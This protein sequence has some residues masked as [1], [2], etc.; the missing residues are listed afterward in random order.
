MPSLFNAAAVK[1]RHLQCFVAVMRE[2]SLQ[3]AA[4]SLAISQPAASKTL[5]E[6]EELLGVRLFERGR[7]GAA[8]LHAAQVFQRYAT[9]CLGALR[10]GIDVVTHEQGQRSGRL[11]L[12]L[13]PTA[14]G[15]W[16][17]DAISEFST[18]WPD[19]TV[20]IVTAP[21]ADLLERMHDAAL[22]L[23]I[24]RV[25]EPAA[26]AGLTFEYLRGEPLCVVVRNGH[27]LT[28][29]T[30]LTGSE[31]ADYPLVMPSGGTIIRQSADR[32]MREFGLAGRAANIEILS[33]SVGRALVRQGDF[34]WVVPRSAV[35][36]DIADGWLH[37]LPLA[38][39]GSEE[40][41]GLVLAAEPLPSATLRAMVTALRHCA[42]RA[43][44]P[45]SARAIQ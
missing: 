3:K 7:N 42:R 23:A 6:L 45:V 34:V 30:R 4:D 29:A 43:T 18:V 33:V 17:A 19:V 31:L 24:G 26:L 40:S 16:F 9:A 1:L 22:D 41:V 20:E 13:L 28:R 37:A 39:A 15:S 14:A 44:A 25:V 27:P 5:A 38:T 11:R 8:P 12:G 36:A 10:E 32:L 2:G 21:N 35:A